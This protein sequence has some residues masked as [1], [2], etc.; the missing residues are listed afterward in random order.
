MSAA[1][2]NNNSRHLITFGAWEQ[3]HTYGA[4]MK[5]HV[6]F[7]EPH[8]YP[9]SA[10]PAHDVPASLAI[11]AAWAAHG[12]PVFIGETSNFGA[13]RSQQSRF[14]KSMRPHVKGVLSHY[15]GTPPSA[16]C[17]DIV[18]A[19]RR[20][21]AY[22]MADVSPF[23]RALTTAGRKTTLRRFVNV[24]PAPGKHLHSEVTDTNVDTAL[25]FRINVWNIPYTYSAEPDTGI[26]LKVAEANTA[27]LVRFWAKSSST[28]VYLTDPS[29]TDVANAAI[30][31]FE[32]DRLLGFIHKTQ[33]SGTNPLYKCT[34]SSDEIL[35]QSAMCPSGYALRPTP[36]GY[37]F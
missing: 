32:Y 5:D 31:G 20:D 33:V 1:I 2:R 16:T 21:E 9:K 6:D 25:A 27:A 30:L 23:F 14:I 7:Y 36:L 4:W 28:A 24:T 3:W 34:S 17:S 18:C 12:R 26:L 13:G 10:E 8:I 29:A 22:D 35:Q 19:I 37:V 15:Y 11:V